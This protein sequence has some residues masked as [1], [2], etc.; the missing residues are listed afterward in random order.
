MTSFHDCNQLVFKVD[1]VIEPKMI[2]V[3]LG[4]K[5]KMNEDRFL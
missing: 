5:I 3:R 4:S 1:H 2:S